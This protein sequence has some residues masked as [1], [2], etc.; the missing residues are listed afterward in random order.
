MAAS[1][2]LKERKTILLHYKQQQKAETT[3]PVQS[4]IHCL[5]FQQ[6]QYIICFDNTASTKRTGFETGYQCSCILYNS[7]AVISVLT[8]LQTSNRCSPQLQYT[9]LNKMLTLSLETTF[10][11]PIPLELPGFQIKL[12]A[13]KTIQNLLLTSVTVWTKMAP[14]SMKL[15]NVLS[16]KLQMQHF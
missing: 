3:Q 15:K 4:E 16:T 10:W 7:L 13:A 1:R 11:K 9:N 5:Q 12:I 8:L 6:Q 2:R 14:H